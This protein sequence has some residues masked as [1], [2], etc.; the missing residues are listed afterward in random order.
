MS[1]RFRFPIT[2]PQGIRV[3][4][5]I[6]DKIQKGQSIGHLANG[7]ISA[8]DVSGSLGIAPKEIGKY[9]TVA[10]GHEVKSGEI[11]ARRK[12]AFKEKH[13]ISPLTGKVQH[14]S[15]DNGT[16]TICLKAGSQKGLESPVDGEV[17]NLTQEHLELNVT[18]KVF[19]APEIGETAGWGPLEHVGQWGSAKIEDITIDYSGKIVVSADKINN[20][21]VSKATALD[22]AG[23]VCAGLSHKDISVKIPFVCFPSGDDDQMDRRL[24]ENL[25]ESN[26]K[27]ALIDPKEKILGIVEQ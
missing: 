18:G 10:V 21:W 24:W 11:V 12:T 8:I 17:V 7:P 1:Q 19:P 22:V 15:L 13:V 5:K 16:I 20:A 27:I 4:V 26:E 6:G 3:A 2:I 23:V 25:I 14:V 9:L